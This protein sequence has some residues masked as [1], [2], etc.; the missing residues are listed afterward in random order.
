MAARGLL[1]YPVWDSS[2]RWF[3]WIN[4]VCVLAL[5]AIGTAILYE[6]ELGV[7]DSGKILL[8]TTHVW[9]GYVFAVNLVWRLV[10]A[11]IGNRQA[12]WSAIIP[13]RTGYGVAFNTYLRELIDGDVRPY[14]GTT[15]SPVRRSRY[16]VSSLSCR[17]LLVSFSPERT[18]TTH[19]SVVG[20]RAGLQRPG[21]IPRR[22]LPT[23]R[24]ASIPH[25]GRRCARFAL[26]FLPSTTGTST[27]FSAQS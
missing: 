25:R 4:F 26:Y 3:H 12:K 21:S 16:T 13:F 20:L 10:W 9:F 2:T 24:L 18:S 8:K 27:P 15:L 17:L 19:H 23:I 6:K 14:L 1:S 22:L 11:F 5:V 7:T